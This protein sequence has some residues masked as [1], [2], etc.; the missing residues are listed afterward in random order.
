MSVLYATFPRSGSSMMR[1]Y[2]ENV[3]GIA[4]GSDLNLKHT[5]NVALQHAVSK[6]EGY[7][8]DDCWIKKT[9]WPFNLPFQKSH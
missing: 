3:S 9:H 7:I 4:T 6:G 1:K 2:F 5:L 8:T